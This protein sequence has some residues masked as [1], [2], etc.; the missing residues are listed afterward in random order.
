[1]AEGDD[2]GHEAPE[3][4]LFRVRRAKLQRIIDAGGEP[5]KPCYGKP[6]G[7]AR[8]AEL[9]L[10]HQGLEADASS[11][12]TVS[13]AGRLIAR[14]QHGK[15]TFADLQDSSGKIQ[16]VLREDVLGDKYG[17]LGELDLGDWIGVS[18]EVLRTRRGELSVLVHSYEL[19]S[20]SLRPLPEK[21]HGL[22]DRE[23]RYRQRYL[24]LLM[25]EEARRVEP[26]RGRL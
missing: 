1:M 24:D 23:Q 8:S 25:N 19:L 12:E 3:S 6:G 13:V 5:Y 16:L 17:E 9:H 21:W 2:K 14:R 20:K 11:G 10:K 26:P 4:E 15:A 7:I 18:G 22:K